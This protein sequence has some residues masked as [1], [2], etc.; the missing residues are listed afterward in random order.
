MTVLDKVLALRPTNAVSRLGK[1]RLPLLNPRDLVRALQAEPASLLCVPVP[2]L[3][4]LPG[5]LRA[6]R[7][8]DSVL[9]LACAHP[10]PKRNTA[11]VFFDAVKAAADEIEHK[12]PVFLQA[13]PVRITT[14][15][16]KALEMAAAEVFKFVD[17]G[18]SLISLD[19]SALSQEDG[20]RIAAGLAR[21]AVERELSIEIAAPLEG[22]GRPTPDTL[23]QYL[24]ALGKKGLEPRF[25]RL[26]STTI[27]P[28]DGGATAEGDYGALRELQ[29]IAS[30]RG[31]TLTIEDRGTPMRLL[32]SWTAAGVKKVD[33]G[34]PFARPVLNAL[35]PE[36]QTELRTKARDVGVGMAEML[37]RTDAPLSQVAPAGKERVEAVAYGEA[38]SLFESFGA[39]GSATKAMNFL[40]EQAGY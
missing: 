4:V 39:V 22:G 10:F 13:G 6:A 2:A 19:T 28:L 3:D 25:V 35:T 32:S 40:S 29:E 34:Q 21:L 9:G 38:F 1:S 30:E 23:R 27:L 16:Q 37:G 24:E 5:L 20:I 17:A 36:R 7:D 33:V 8:Q 31:A 11:A 12:R 14:L 15:E 18:F 26:R